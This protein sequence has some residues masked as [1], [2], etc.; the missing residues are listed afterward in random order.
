MDAESIIFCQYHLLHGHVP[1]NNT[2]NNNNNSFFSEGKNIADQIT[3]MGHLL[4]SVEVDM[5]CAREIASS[6]HHNLQRKIPCLR[7]QQCRLT[8]IIDLL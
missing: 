8:K 7:Q 2:T 1:S 5:V 6:Q 4:L 3:E